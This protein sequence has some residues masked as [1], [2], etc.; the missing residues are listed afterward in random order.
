[1]LNLL[2]HK[3][4]FNSAGLDPAC[5]SNSFGVSVCAA[6]M[7]EQLLVCVMDTCV[8]SIFNIHLSSIHA[9]TSLLEGNGG[10]GPNWK[11]VKHLHSENLQEAE[12]EVQEA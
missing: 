1:M 4:H 2:S 9:T 3:L 10:I 5:I 11:L 12:I 8:L 6:Q 7:S